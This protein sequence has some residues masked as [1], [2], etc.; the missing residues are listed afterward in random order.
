MKLIKSIKVI[1]WASYIIFNLILTNILSFSI[2]IHEYL[3]IAILGVTWIGGGIIIYLLLKRITTNQ[4][5]KG[6]KTKIDN[7]S[8]IITLCSKDYPKHNGIVW[9]VSSNSL[10]SIS[11]KKSQTIP[12][13]SIQHVEIGSNILACS[14]PVS[15]VVGVNDG[16]GAEGSKAVVREEALAIIEFSPQDMEIAQAIHECISKP[17]NVGSFQFQ[18]GFQSQSTSFNERP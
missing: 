8:G 10:T 1:V 2:T 17:Q 16:S 13:S 5:F 7:E 14:G 4:Y 15:H 18:F 9:N 12:F 3:A 6:H 11:N